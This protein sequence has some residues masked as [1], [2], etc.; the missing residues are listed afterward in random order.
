MNRDH[1]GVL[2]KS[3]PGRHRRE[4]GKRRKGPSSP[5]LLWG[6]QVR[7]RGHVSVRAGLSRRQ[8]KSSR[9]G[10]THLWVQGRSRA[11]ESLREP[12]WLRRQS[13]L[14]SFRSR[15]LTSQSTEPAKKGSVRE[16]DSVLGRASRSFWRRTSQPAAE[17]AGAKLRRCSRGT[18][19]LMDEEHKTIS[20]RSAV[21][22]G[23]GT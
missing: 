4:R 5:M 14:G 8:S 7:R 22:P 11:F 15:S 17:L 9:S 19:G 20:T 1:V 6:R 2:M 3:R 10:P 23:E 21:P 16:A 13:L 12:T 18:S